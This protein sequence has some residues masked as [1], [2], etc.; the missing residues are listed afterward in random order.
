MPGPSAALRALTASDTLHRVLLSAKQADDLHEAFL[1]RKDEKGSGLSVNFDC[2]A[3][4]AR[5]Q[6]CFSKTY[7]V[8]SLIVRIVKELDLDVVPDEPR[9]ANIVGI[10]YKEDD[11]AKAEWFA[12]QL[13]SR[14]TAVLKERWKQPK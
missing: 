14:V 9:H 1:L 8:A 6:D 10:P 4:E 7:G 2:T 13:S 11:E 5:M 12:S 3:D